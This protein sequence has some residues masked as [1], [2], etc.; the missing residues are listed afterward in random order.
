MP[1]SGRRLMQKIR[2]L[3][4]MT[5]IYFS[6]YVVGPVEIILKSLWE[7]F[8]GFVEAFQWKRNNFGPMLP[9]DEFLIKC[10]KEAKRV[11]LERSNKRTLS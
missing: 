8:K 2:Y 5:V 7:G 6:L 3:Y 10:R 4:Y 1:G 9:D 11:S